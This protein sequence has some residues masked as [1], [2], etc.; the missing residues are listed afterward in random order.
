MF[1]E[2]QSESNYWVRNTPGWCT[3]LLVLSSSSPSSSSS[4][5]KP[6]PESIVLETL[7][8]VAPST[9]DKGRL[10]SLACRSIN[11]RCRFRSIL[12]RIAAESSV[13]V[14]GESQ[15]AGSECDGSICPLIDRIS[16]NTFATHITREMLFNYL[17]WVTW[18]HPCF[19]FSFLR[20][21]FKVCLELRGD[22]T[23]TFWR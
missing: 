15:P 17:R 16:E 7:A 12:A 4:M 5:K 8:D 10:A 6:A 22:T 11:A 13:L 3:I 21:L 9:A 18:K 19:R 1:S 23:A 20:P 14:C 2:V